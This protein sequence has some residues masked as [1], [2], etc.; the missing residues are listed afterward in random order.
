M[1]EALDWGTG[2]PLKASL[3]GKMNRLE[4]HHIFPK[5]QLYRR[6]FK[7]PEVNALA[8]FCFLTK[9][10]NLNISDLLPV[11]YFPAVEEA[12][13]GALA[14]QW[15]P[16]DPALWKI[17]NYLGFLEARKAL[18]AAEVNL[19]MA[20]LLHGDVRWLSGSEAAR[21]ERVA[22]AVVGGITSD[23]EE[24]A[25][26][27]LNAWAEEQGLPRGVL[28][29]DFADA[30]TGEQIAVF[31]LVWPVGIQEELSQPVAV[32]L[33]ESSETLAIASKAGFRCFTDVED[34]KRYVEVEILAED[35]AA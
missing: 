22:P 25:L 24:E 3:L 26:E 21:V 34:F 19:R 10:T 30:E 16:D 5:A 29:Y 31:D 23:A 32:L 18:L 27:A 14:S 1:G 13:P 7:R 8:N 4:V 33:N 28:S 12:H 20:E 15:I 9:D 2:L 17:E 11:D 35:V 6:S